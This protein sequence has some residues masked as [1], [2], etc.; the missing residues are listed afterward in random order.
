MNMLRLGYGAGFPGTGV[1]VA[2]RE[3]EGRLEKGSQKL[4]EGARAK[5]D[6]FGWFDLPDSPPGG[7]RY[8]GMA[9]GFRFGCADRDR[10]ILPGG[11]MISSLGFLSITN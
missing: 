7:V 5:K 10:R 4:L 8:G 6:G 11:R 9:P 1:G 3:M 2:L